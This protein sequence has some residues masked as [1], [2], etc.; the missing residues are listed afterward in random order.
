[1]GRVLLAAMMAA[2]LTGSLPAQ[3]VLAVSPGQR[4]KVRSPDARGVFVV[5]SAA[6]DTLVLAASSGETRAVPIASISQFEV[7]AGERTRLGGFARGAGFGLLIGAGVGGAWGLA[8]GDDDCAEASWCFIEFS[9]AE[10]AMLGGAVLGSL[11]AIIGGVFGVANPGEHWRRVPLRRVA[12]APSSGGF[13]AVVSL[14][15]GR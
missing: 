11:G 13:A 5:Q 14:E 15:L 4:V 1:M 10:K 6:A 12:V 2:I 3:E 8:D 9:A 7:S